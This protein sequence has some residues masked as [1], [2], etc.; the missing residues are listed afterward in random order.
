MSIDDAEVSRLVVTQPEHLAGRV[1]PLSPPEVVIGHSDTADVS[2]PDEF[3]S[4][5]HALVTVD[6][7]GTATIRDLNSTG[8]TF[9]NGERIDAPRILQPG[10]T[11]GLADV[12]TRYEPAASARAGATTVASAVVAPAVAA[13][14]PAED[15]PE[16][17]HDLDPASGAKSMP[18]PAI[19]ATD[20]GDAGDDPAAR[21]LATVATSDADESYVV[22]GE[23][24]WS[25]GTP[26][27]GV[28]VRAVDHD[29]RGEQQLGPYAP[30]FE[31]ETRT[32]GS[33]RYE[34]PYTAS[35]FA[36]AEI[37]TADLI[38][39]A[40]DAN[41]A[42][43]ATSP[44]TFNAPA[45]AEIDLTLSG[46]VAGEPSEYERLVALLSPLLQDADPPQVSVLEPSD[47]DFLLG[48]TGADRTQLSDLLSAVGLYQ[49]ASAALGADIS[50]NA[51]PVAGTVDGGAAA[52]AVT[53][54][55]VLI[56][57]FYGLLREGVSAAWGA[58]LQSGEA[59][60]DSSL[61]AAVNDGFVPTGLSQ[62]AD[63]IAQELG[64]LAARQLIAPS[65]ASTPTVVSGLL[66]AANLSAAQQQ[67]LLTSAGS[68]SGTPEE[69]WASLPSQAGFDAASV[70]RLQL[71]LQLGLLTGNH[72]PL[73]QQLLSQPS[74]TS[75]KDLVSMDTAAWTQLLSTQVDGQ[76][77]GV[78]AGVPGT[79]PAEQTANYVQ[80]IVSTLQAAF[81]NETIAHLVATSAITTDVSTQA[82][83]GQFFANSPDFDIRTT[84]ISSYVA[85]NEQTAF[86][87]IP[88]AEQPA[89]VVGAQ[90]RAR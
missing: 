73:V 60:I 27:I 13:A 11:V 46:A 64:N 9:V 71:T 36:S 23:V 14:G 47:L 61:L 43:V 15:L 84:R 65:S 3:V 18:A 10:D 63:Q 49:D 6:D 22:S 81:P 12:E 53:A 74:V 30:R 28:V 31:Q 78:P 56:P 40:L 24:T 42:V 58:L 26:V 50:P 72:V 21:A 79:T 52:A 88:I 83:I 86:A 16:A 19:A 7:S 1:L 68:A 37:K 8:G 41:G 75:V 35:Q 20:G 87:G 39:R 89:L 69:F 90:M 34:I 33:G 67:T 70:A 57:A 5:R 82:A 55:D 80:G 2:L 38:V 29:L 59:S 25:D 62:T 32:D 44:T 85:A 54:P 48:E 4:R 45:M 66:S 51:A 17:E 77:I 76:P